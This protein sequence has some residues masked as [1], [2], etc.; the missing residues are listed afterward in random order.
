MLPHN[1]TIQL[2]PNQIRRAQRARYRGNDA[3]LLRHRTHASHQAHLPPSRV[4]MLLAP[5]LA[6]PAF[7]HHPIQIATQ[8][9]AAAACALGLPFAHSRLRYY[10]PAGP[11]A[12]SSVTTIS[13]KIH[14]AMLSPASSR[15][16]A[17]TF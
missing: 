13:T 9:R 16:D 12:S 4:H 17:L 3:I 6:G 14:S 1:A 8:L 5:L 11:G 10:V 7:L 2:Q 15:H